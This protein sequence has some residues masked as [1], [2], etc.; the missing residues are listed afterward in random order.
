MFLIHVA[1]LVGRVLLLQLE[2][3]TVAVEHGG[4]V[5]LG[6]GDHAF[7]REGIGQSVTVAAALFQCMVHQF[8][9]LLWI[10]VG[11]HVGIVGIDG[12]QVDLVLLR[13]LLDGLVEIFRGDG[14]IIA[15]PV[16]D[17]HQVTGIIVFLRVLLLLH[18]S[19][20]F[21]GLLHGTVVVAV[22]HV[23]RHHV[24][25]GRII[26]VMIELRLFFDMVEHFL[27]FGVEFCLVAVDIQSS[28]LN[29]ESG[30]SRVLCLLVCCLP[31][32]T[33]EELTD[34][35]CYAQDETLHIS[36]LYE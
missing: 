14:D 28:E 12:C 5:A 35:D 7:H 10:L 17:R 3:A 1:D 36:G 31:F 9:R 26:Q 18:L 16:D 27:R 15:I 4:T 19:H 13:H 25:E 33:R 20:Q 21:A 24:D 30:G 34:H 23:E 32:Y 2:V 6:E 29:G 11:H 22:V 8:H